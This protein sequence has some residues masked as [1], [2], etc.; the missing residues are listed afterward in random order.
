MSMA[1]KTAQK[2]LKRILACLLPALAAAFFAAGVEA[3]QTRPPR[4]V[5]DFEYAEAR[6][7]HEGLAAVRQEDRWGYI[8]LR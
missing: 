2:K 5:I 1:L 6:D 8:R 4:V 7:F 3:A